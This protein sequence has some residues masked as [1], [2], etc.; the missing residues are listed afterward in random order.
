MRTKDRVNQLASMPCNQVPVP[1]QQLVKY[2]A[3][4]YGVCGELILSA[5]AAYCIVFE[6]TEGGECG[7]EERR[8]LMAIKPEDL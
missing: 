3:S 6:N 4:K 8:F 7:D 5:Y 1:A 2:L